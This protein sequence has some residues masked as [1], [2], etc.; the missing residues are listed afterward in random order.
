MAA[1]W[2]ELR[3]GVLAED[4]ILARIDA[5]QATMGDAI[6]RNFERWPIEQIG[7]GNYFYPVSSYA[8]ED[9]HVRAWLGERLRWMDENVAAW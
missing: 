1:R 5:M 7:Y 9:A 6:D 2:A 8:E 3:A 4:A